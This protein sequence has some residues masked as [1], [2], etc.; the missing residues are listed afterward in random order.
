VRLAILATVVFLAFAP[1]LS[2]DE[3]GTLISD[4]MA[5]FSETWGSMVARDMEFGQQT[6]RTQSSVVRVM[7]LPLRPRFLGPMAQ[8]VGIEQDFQAPLIQAPQTIG[9]S[10]VG[11]NLQDEINLGVGAIPPDSMGTIGPNHFLEMINSSV[12]AYTR[13]GTRLSNVTLDSFFTVTVNGTTYP[14]FGTS[15]PHVIYD[16][17]SGRWF[18]C[19]VEF[20][21]AAGSDNNIMFAVSRTS[22][23]LN[24]IWDKYVIPV[25]EPDS[26]NT[27][28][29][30]DFDTL[31]TDD[32]GVYFGMNVFPSTGNTDWAKIAATPKAPLLAASPSLG[33]V[34][35][36]N[37]ITDMYASPEPA[38]N[39]D[40]SAGGRE[41]FVA[42]STTAFGNVN[43]R[44]LAWIGGAPSISGTAVLTTPAYGATLE[45]PAS[46]SSTNIDVGDDRMSPCVIRGS[47][48]WVSRNVGLNSS[49]G[50][51]R[52]NRT[53]CEWLELDVT[54]SI[55]GLL[56]SGRVY[57]PTPSSPVYYYYPTIMVNGQGNVAMGFSG[58]G[59]TQFVG[60]YTCGRL[61]T[62]TPNVMGAV[63]QVKAGQA[64]YLRLDGTRNRWGDYSHTTLDPNDDMS[65]WTIQE[66]ATNVGSSIWGTWVARLLSPAPTLSN[67]NGT[68]CAGQTGVVL[69]L[70][71]TGFYDPGAGYANRLS[72]ALL[73]GSP[74]GI[75]NYSVTYNGPSSVT[76]T[77]DIAANASA[78]MRDIVLTNPDGQSV[79]VVGGFT[80][81]TPVTFGSQP[82]SVVACPTTPV[83][84]CVTA[85]GT[86]PVTYQWKKN[87][88]SIVGATSSCYSILSCAIGDSGVYTCVVTDPCGPV[89]SSPATLAVAQCVT[90]PQAKALPDGTVV[91][92]IGRLVSAIFG[93]GFYLEESKRTSGIRVNGSGVTLGATADVSGTIRTGPS[94]ERYIDVGLV[95]PH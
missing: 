71:G 55:A 6:V 66:Y 33:P 90:I 40:G 46:G 13:T 12:A 26:G 20:G 65:L 89:A 15:D 28:F 24:G 45:A 2:A 91:A 62:D 1:A 27:N 44:T 61:N 94:K 50:A 51:S 56:Q 18:A 52:P 70:T 58:S 21:T 37:N 32:N 4:G 80:V 86:A 25:A 34:Y 48:L 43:Y 47:R 75:S 31:G 59:S 92:V 72:V 73:G 30:N 54:S 22:D 68:G 60:T 95:V 83:Q 3:P 29:F 39:L 11:L 49:G 93:D 19:C 74:N 35:Q 85:S 10:F 87:G 53:G 41:W 77:F 23:P 7:P 36:W 67:P 84:F 8:G 14:R 5:P 38:H 76:V 81:D 63:A 17:R 42:S 64:S 57:D 79:T 69:N 78:G 9:M 82:S 88:V 16:R